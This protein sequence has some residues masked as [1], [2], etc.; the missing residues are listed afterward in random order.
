MEPVALADLFDF[1]DHRLPVDEETASCRL[2]TE[3]DV[4]RDGEAWYEHEVLVDH[5]Y[6][7]LDGVG[8][9]PNIHLLPVDEETALVGPVEAVEDAHEN[10]LAG[11][12][13]AEEAVNLPLLHREV[14]VVVC[15][16]SGEGLGDTS[17]L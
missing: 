4:L 17:K 14:Y 8:G 7:V 13:L 9:T 2:P 10:C 11:A 15:Q 6:T 5:A 3:D 1:S 12:V 16:N